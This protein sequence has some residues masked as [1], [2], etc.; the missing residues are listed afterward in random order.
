MRKQK[1]LR[2]VSGIYGALCL[3]VF[4][5]CLFIL[6]FGDTSPLGLSILELAV[7]T[8]WGGVTLFGYLIYCIRSKGNVTRAS[9]GIVAV[10]AA[11]PP[12]VYFCV[13]CISASSG[14]SLSD[15]A[16]WMVFLIPSLVAALLILF[17]K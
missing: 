14:V 11:I 10:V 8:V 5:F 12:T 17:L 4:L 13:G 7:A 2:W 6:V 9:R 15:L 3:A 1:V 16:G